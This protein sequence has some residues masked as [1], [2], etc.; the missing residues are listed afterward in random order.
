MPSDS[1]LSMWRA[2]LS[3]LGET[4]ETTT[5]PLSA[6]HFCD[7]EAD[8]NECAELVKQ[9]IKTATAPSLWYFETQRESLPGPGDLQVITDWAGEAQ[10]VIRTIRVEIVP[11]NEVSAEHAAAEGEGDRSLA[12][13]RRVHWDYYHRELEGSS[14]APREDMPIVCKRFEV[15]YPAPVSPF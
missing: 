1:V 6:W 5:R 10:C 14:F 15:V 8:A 3:S 4:P 2:S 13:W 11:F 7:N 12:F 9:G